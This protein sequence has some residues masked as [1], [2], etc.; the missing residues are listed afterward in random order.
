MVSGYWLSPFLIP[1]LYT[2]FNCWEILMIN[3]FPYKVETNYDKNA[4]YPDY[5]PQ[6]TITFTNGSS[7]IWSSDEIFSNEIAAKNHTAQ[8][9][10]SLQK[11]LKNN[12]LTSL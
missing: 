11:E 8:I 6:V 3:I 7:F 1:A 10:E 4:V 5:R 12:G 2:I 9:V